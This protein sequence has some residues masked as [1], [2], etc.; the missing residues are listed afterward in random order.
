MLTVLLLSVIFLVLCL[1]AFCEDA[2]DVKTSAAPVPPEAPKAASAPAESRSDLNLLGRTNSTS[3][4][5]RRNENVQFN[6][7]DNN[8]LKELN[9]RLGTT[10]TIVTEFRPER[11]YYGVEFGN[12]PPALLHSSPSRFSHGPHGLLFA[13]HQNSVF[14][15]RTFFQVG[16]VKPARENNYGLNFVTGLW[17]NGFLTLD[18]SQQ[19]IR[20]NVNGNVLVPRPDERIPLA[21]DPRVRHIIERFVAAY[22]LALPNRLDVDPRALNTNAPQHIDTNSAAI[23]FDQIVSSR[24]RLIARHSWT[25]QQ[26]DPF[27]FVAGQNPVT[28]TRSHNARLTWQRVWS[29]ATT[30]D[31]SVGFDRVH[32]LLMAEPN[33]VGP[34]VQIGTVF[35]TL[36]PGSNVP[37]DRIQNRFRH[38]ALFNHQRGNHRFVM[39]G[40]LTRLQFNGR[41][42]SSNRGNVY[43]RND[44]GRDAISNFRLGIPSRYSTGLGELDRGFRNWEQH[45]YAGDTWRARP[46]VTLSLGLRWQPFP[47]PKD[48]N[49][50]TRIPYDCDCNNVAPRF[51]FAWRASRHSVVR[52]AY[53]LFYG[54]LFPVTFQQLRWNSPEFQKIEVQAPDLL[55]PLKDAV[56]SPDGRSTV[57]VVPRN[58]RAPYSHQYNLSWETSLRANWRLQIGYVGSRTHK[59]LM[60]W[61]LNRGEP[62]PGIPQTTATINERRADQRYF[63][64]R[65]VQNGSR[66]YFDAARVTLSIPEWRGLTVDASYWFSKAIDTGSAYTNTAAGDDA[67]QGFPQ[68][69]YLVQ[70][71]L[72]GPS[73]FDQSHAALLRLRYLT[74]V[75]RGFGKW[76]ISA[77]WLGKTGMPFSVISGSDGPGFGN[78]DGTTGD[79]PN[80]LDPAVLGR[81]LGDPDTSVALLP[82]SAFRFINPND[83]RGNLGSNTFRRGGIRNVNASLARTWSIAGERSLT[84]RAES[85]NLTNTPQFAPPN[86]DL[87]SPAFAKITN[88]LNDGRTFQF[89]VQLRF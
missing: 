71:D 3:G 13:T 35:T 67:V 17:K 49:N 80:L 59:L 52:G 81:G 58:L 30:G 74:P 63:D 82:R 4:E 28:T 60:L 87:S 78:V 75:W 24:D 27:Q 34:Q 12:A 10:A 2:K 46:N 40:E 44:F 79:R 70:Q 25:T 6:L 48:V 16:G 32:S 51:G 85:I 39:G 21:A 53:G 9:I 33:A 61:H 23:R 68:Y 72:K 38:A 29:A 55:A 56:I 84:F 36:G 64:V 76:A 5:S 19:K 65:V 11:Q 89:T 45:L 83:L 41:E 7:I 15:A 50:R 43:F 14:S 57:F 26:V 47:G 62:V 1:P 77:I 73:A 31:F 86:N 8:A 37:L 88:T 42:A 18:G 20:G 69:Q 22:P 66:A 54:E